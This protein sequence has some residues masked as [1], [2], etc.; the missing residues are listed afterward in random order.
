MRSAGEGEVVFSHSSMPR[1]SQ[2]LRPGSWMWVNSTPIER[3]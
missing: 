1:W 2:L 3:Q